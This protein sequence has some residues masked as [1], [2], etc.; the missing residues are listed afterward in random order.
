MTASIYAIVEGHGEVSAVP[1][2]LRRLAHEQLQRYDVHVFPPHRV[3]KGRILRTDDLERAAELGSRRV[4][5]YGGRG[6]VM[7][8]LDANSDCPAVRAPQLLR[9]LMA[10]VG[11]LPTSVVL[12]KREYEAWF[13]AT[14]S[15]LRTHRRVR[16]AASGP[17]D[18]E[19]IAGAKEYLARQILLAEAAYSETVDQAAFTAIMD[20]AQALRCRSFR[21]LC[22][23]FARLTETF[24]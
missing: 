14:A 15:S 3:S 19:A 5:Q 17:P 2:L 1:I 24:A 9:R 23:D 12:A 22:S 10:V 4:K 21:K 20:L 6:G 8:L 13:L 11:D 18:P 7:L 16:D